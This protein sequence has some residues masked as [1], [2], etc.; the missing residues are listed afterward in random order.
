MSLSSGSGGVPLHELCCPTCGNRFT[1]YNLHS[2]PD[3]FEIVQVQA[4]GIVANARQFNWF[5]LCPNGHK[6]T[7]KTLFRSENGP[8]CVL[9]DRYVGEL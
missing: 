9:L 5:I 7:I 1:D 3:E 6:W 8:D 2:D 4:L